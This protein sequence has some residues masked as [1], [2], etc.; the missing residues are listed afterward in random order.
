MVHALRQSR[1]TILRLER[2]QKELAEALEQE[3][4]QFER[5]QFGLKRATADAAYIKTLQKLRAESRGQDGSA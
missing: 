3:N 2:A 4:K 1:R 5:I